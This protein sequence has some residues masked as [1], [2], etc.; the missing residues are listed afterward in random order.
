MKRFKGFFIVAPIAFLGIFIMGCQKEVLDK[1]PQ[2]FFT[3]DDIWSNID[4]VENYVVNNYNAL[5]GW[6]IDPAYGIAQPCTLSDDAYQMFNYGSIWE[7]NAG[8]LSPD[9]M[10]IWN[11]TWKDAYTY[12]KNVNTYLENIGNVDAP[13]S[14][15]TPLTG[16]MLFI[17]AWQYARLLNLFGGVPMITKVYNLNDNFDAKRGTYQEGINWVVAQLDSSLAMVPAT[18]ESADWG[19]ITKGAVL[20]LKSRIL[21]YAASKLHDPASQPSGPLYSYNDPDKWAKAAAAA[22][23]VMDLNLYSLVPVSTWQDYQQLFLHNNVEIIFAR[24]YD[25]QYLQHGPNLG[26]LNTPNGYHGWSG[27]V[28]TQNLVDAF[29][30]KDGLSIDESQLYNSSANTIYENRELRFYADIVYN[31]CNLRGRAVEFFLPG[32]KDSP[33]GSEGWNYARTGYTM[34]KHMNESVDFQN[35]N[36]TTPRIYFRLAEIYLNYAEAEYHLGNEDIAREYLNKIRARVHLPDVQSS[37]KDL[38]DAIMHERRIELVFEGYHR[39]NDVRR[40]MTAEKYLGENA[41]G[42]GWEK[43][44]NKLSYKFVQNQIRAFKTQMYYL[45]IPRAEIQKTGLEQNKGY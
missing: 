25:A 28:P 42:I 39:F 26:Q 10:S 45:P 23:A 4:L 11:N 12:I 9:N 16:Q 2:Q 24:P 35:T 19:R 1:Q 3:G 13:D 8:Q 30:M 6:S 21:L 34:R 20:A 44:N 15:K 32:G 38:L 41:M 27:N 33:D 7:F 37:G 29:E 17:R 36:P 22:K 31:G 14:I 40:W 18:V 43:A 5:G